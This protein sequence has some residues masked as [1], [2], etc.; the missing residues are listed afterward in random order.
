MTCFKALTASR[1]ALWLKPVAGRMNVPGQLCIFGYGNLNLSAHANLPLYTMRIDG[2]MIRTMAASMLIDWI[3]DCTVISKV[4]DV[5]RKLI[6]GP[7]RTS[8]TARRTVLN[9]LQFLLRGSRHRMT[10]S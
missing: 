6:D 7:A 10:A 4:K 2:T 9:F 3:A 5:G 1:Q 8:F